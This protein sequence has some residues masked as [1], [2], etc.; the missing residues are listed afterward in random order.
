[1]EYKISTGYGVSELRYTST[2][3]HRLQG[4]GEGK[5]ASKSPIV[6]TKNYDVFLDVFD[7]VAHPIEFDHCSGDLT[8]KASCTLDEYVDNQSNGAV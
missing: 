6:C 1:M 4:T 2:P 8:Q 7:K 5:G 3:E